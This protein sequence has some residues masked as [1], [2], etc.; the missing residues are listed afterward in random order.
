PKLLGCLAGAGAG[1]LRGES[2]ALLAQDRGLLPE[3]L[4]LAPQVAVLLVEL[5]LEV[6]QLF[7]PLP[8]AR[9]E[10][11]LLLDPGLLLLPPQRQPL[12]LPA[13]TRLLGGL[14]KI[15]ACRRRLGQQSLEGAQPGPE[16][17][18]C[19]GCPRKVGGEAL[20]ILSQDRDLLAEALGLA[21]QIP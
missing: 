13:G 3:A 7:L 20:A 14:D 21:P 16:L 11:L 4:G 8:T 10:A 2:L 1:M 17:L 19:H 5:P 9:V 15:V 6:F 18:G 12:G